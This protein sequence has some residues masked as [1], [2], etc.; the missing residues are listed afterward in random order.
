MLNGING[1]NKELRVLMRRLE[2]LGFM[3][4]WTSTGH[5]KIKH[6]EVPSAQVIAS[7]SPSDR[8]GILNM[9]STLRRTFPQQTTT[10]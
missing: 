3:L 1:V 9:R 10:L 7:K 4:T 5:V 8:R 2:E 6:P